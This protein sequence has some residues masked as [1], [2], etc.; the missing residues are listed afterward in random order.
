MTRI[1]QLNLPRNGR[2]AQDGGGETLVVTIGIE[3][4]AR[5]VESKLGQIQAA[6]HR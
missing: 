3:P 6:N 5:A 1:A 2:A 4:R